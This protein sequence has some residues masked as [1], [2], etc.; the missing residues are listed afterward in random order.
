MATTRT[1]KT[2]LVL[3]SGGITGVAYEVGA[4]R[5]LDHILTN[6]TVND[7]DIYVGTSAGSVV[8]ASLASGVPPVML[9]GLVARNIPGFRNLRRGQLFRPNFSEVFSRLGGAPALIREAA[10][11]YWRFRDRVPWTEAL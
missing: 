10:T 1:G 2:A 4:L 7:F 8:A 9:A 6:R 5:A 3:A 11:E